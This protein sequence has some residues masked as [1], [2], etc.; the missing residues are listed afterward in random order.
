MNTQ[1]KNEE[2]QQE[3]KEKAESAMRLALIQPNKDEIFH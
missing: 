1:N 2:Q 3:N